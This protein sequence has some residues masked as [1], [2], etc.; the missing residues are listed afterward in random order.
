MSFRNPTDIECTRY[1]ESYV[2][3]GDKSKAFRAAFPKSK[4]KPE[5]I[6]SQASV[7]HKLHMV[8]QRI[9]DLRK[10]INDV[11][12]EKAV[13]TLEQKRALLWDT[14]RYGATEFCTVSEREDSEPEYK[15][16]NPS[17][18]VAA[19]KE[20][21]L[22]DGDHASHIKPDDG[23]VPESGDIYYNVKDASKNA[24]S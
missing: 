4:A 8:C 15:Q 18:T 9:E 21:N 22:M 10:S 5:T 1:A 3:Y 24:D 7:Y 2:L 11:A 17:A 6:H 16:R 14:A 23:E 20:L 12:N 19:V 13:A